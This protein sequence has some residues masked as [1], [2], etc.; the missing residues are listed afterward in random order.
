VE[1]V[2][3][4]PTWGIIII[5]WILAGAVISFLTR[6]CMAKYYIEVLKLRDEASD[7]DPY[8]RGFKDGATGI[9]MYYA[10]LARMPDSQWILTNCMNKLDTR[11]KLLNTLTEE[12][13]NALYESP[14]S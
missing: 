9:K 11:E 6:K 2:H 5:V 14:N 1:E 3:K 10:I 13:K 4:M 12:E 7:T 8:Q